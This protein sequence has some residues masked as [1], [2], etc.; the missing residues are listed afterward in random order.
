MNEQ[1][2]A[3]PRSDHPRKWTATELASMSFADAQSQI[4]E[5]GLH[6]FADWFFFRYAPEDAHDRSTFHAD[7][8]ALVHRIY[9]KAQE[10]LIKQ[11]SA[12]M[13][14]VTPSLP[15]QRFTDGKR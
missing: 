1:G 12:A 2:S 3:P 7:L 11:M 6:D 13:S 4:T 5:A 9:V 8:M 14:L 10:P 15:F